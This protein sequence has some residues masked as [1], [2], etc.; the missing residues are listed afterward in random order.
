MQFHEFEPH[1]SLARHVLQY[2]KFVAG[3]FEDVPYM[4]HVAPD[5]CVSLVY[6]L[7]IVDTPGW[8]GLS[9]PRLNEIRVPV[10]PGAE[11][12]GVRFWPDALGPLLHVA[13]PALPADAESKAAEIVNE[14]KRRLSGCGTFGDACD[15]FDDV[16]MGLLPESGP[17]DA[18]VRQGVER[19]VATQ[20]QAS[21]REMAGELGLSER[22]FQRRFRA[23][24]GLTPKQFARIRRFRASASN[25]LRQT[26]ET[27]ARVATENGYADQ[28]HMTREFTAL[29]GLAPTTFQKRVGSIE[30]H[31]VR[32]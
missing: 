25:V 21:I 27:W 30:H 8:I 29:I 3:D 20:G 12:W 18:I 28:A 19:I 2:W 4:H 9:G 17:L 15:V 6:G 16:L 26:P 24:V 13:P 11:W 23:A 1:P 22:Q 31:N 10:R 7:P 14:V 5:G 32:P